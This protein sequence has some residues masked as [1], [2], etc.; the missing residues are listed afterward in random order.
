MK[1]SKATMC[2]ALHRL[3]LTPKRPLHRAL[4]GDKRAIEHWLAEKHPAIQK[5]V[6]EVGATIYFGDEAG[7]SSRH[8]SGT[9]CALEG[10]T[11]VVATTRSAVQPDD[12]LGHLCAWRH[13][14]HGA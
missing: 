14:F 13:T 7:I 6:D 11:P 5:Q 12:D 2:R 9:T 3:G 8:H 1:V 4:Q 10:G